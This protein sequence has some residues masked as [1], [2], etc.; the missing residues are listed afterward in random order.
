[1]SNEKIFSLIQELNL[2]ENNFSFKIFK[3]FYFLFKAKKQIKIIIKYI[4]IIIEAI[5]FISYI[6]S[7]NHFDSWKLDINNLKLISN[8]TGVFKLSILI[9]YINYKAYSVILYIFLIFIFF[10]CLIVFVQILI[11]NSS[12]N[13]YRFNNIIRLFIDILIIIFYIPITEIILIP[14]KCVD[15]KV[16]GVKNGETCWT[17][18]HYLNMALGILSSILFFIW[19]IFMINFSFY[20]F[21]HLESTIRIN[22]NNDIIIIIMKL[23]LILQYLL[24]TNEYISL[25]ILLSVSI[26]IFFSCKYN[27]T[28]NN[29]YL[30]MAVN[31]KNSIVMWSYF[32][33]LISKIF[34]QYDTNEF[35]Y[36]LVIGYPFIVYLSIIRIKEKDFEDINFTENINNV[37]NYIRKINFNIRL[38][39]SFIEGNRSIRNF[40]ENQE[41]KD[42][43]LLKGF[44]RF[45]LSL[46]PKDDCPLRKFINNE[47]NANIQKQCLLN[48]MNIFFNKGFKKFP[49]S[50]RL[51]IIYIQFNYRN[52]SNL[53]KVK[54]SL[55][56]L[57]TMECSIKDKYIIYCLEQNIQ[58]K[59]IIK[60]DYSNKNEKN[61]ESQLDIIEQKYQK[62]KYLIENSIKLYVEFWGIFSNN[63]TSILN[64]NTLYSIGGKLNI[65]LKEIN[66]LWENELKNKKINIENQYI[67]QLYSKFLLE[68]LWDRKKSLEISNKL[69]YE[70]LNNF[71]L[72]DKKDKEEKNK[73]SSIIESLIDNE[74]FLLFCSCD[75]KGNIK[76]IQCSTSLTQLLGYQ[77]Y[78]IIGKPIEIIFP[79]LLVEEQLKY[80]EDFIKLSSNGKNNE[81]EFLT[82]EEKDLNKKMK[83][84]IVKNSIGYILPLFASFQTINDND[85]SEAHLIKIKM[86]MKELKSEY[87]YYILTNQD[88]IIENISLGAINLGLSLDLLKNY[89]IKIDTLI[90]TESD[91]II[92]IYENY[93]KY[94]EE[95]NIVVWI[96]PYLI[97]PKYN[98][99]KKKIK[100]DYIEKLIEKSK[101]I[102]IYIQI[103]IIKFNNENYN[104]PIFFFKFDEI[105]S[106]KKKNI[107]KNEFFIPKCDNNL[108]M[109]DI[110][111]LEYIR[112]LVVNK[113]SG[114]RNVRDIDD[115]KEHNS[116]IH[117]E[118]NKKIKKLKKNLEIEQENESSDDLEINKNEFLLTKE[119]IIEL[120]GSTYIEIK[121]FIFSL[122]II[123]TDI[124]FERFRP[125]GE[126]YSASKITESL[127]KIHVNN[128]IKL[129]NKNLK[130]EQK[131]KKTKK[132]YI[133]NIDSPKSSNTNNCL[134]HPNSSS[135]IEFNGKNSDLEK[136]EINKE[137]TSDL[138]SSLSNI[139]KSNTIN[140]I[141]LLVWT[142]FFEIL[143]FVLI[144]FILVHT[145][146]KKIKKK[147]Y[148]L[149]NGYKIE[150]NFL[151]IK[152]FITEGVLGISLNLNY[153]P[154]VNMGGL[155]PF[156]E[157]IIRALTENREEF[158]EI[159]D[160][161]TSNELCK[162]YKNFMSNKV[163]NISTRTLNKTENI[164]IL[165]NSGMTRI[166]S[167]VNN[168]IYE[169]NLMVMNNR[170]TYEIMN[171]LINE[172]YINW[173]KVI[174]ILFNDSI[175]AT[176]LKLPLIIILSIYFIDSFII[177]FFLLKLLSKFSLD[178]EKP[179]NLFLTLKKNV[180]ENLKLSAENFSNKLLNK[181]FDNEDKEEES[182]QD[183]RANIQQNDINI[184]KFKSANEYN[185]SIKKAFSFIL[186]IIL[187]VFF[188]LIY[189]F[190]FTFKY[191]YFRKKMKSI[192]Q[193]INLFCETNMAQIEYI[194][195]INI[196]KSYLFNKTIPILNNKS[197]TNIF[198]E[199]FMKSSQKLEETI[200]STSKATS[201][202]GKEYLKKFSKYFYSDFSELNKELF[203][204]NKALFGEK[205]KNGLKPVQI[206][207]YEIIRYYSLK[208]CISY[209]NHEINIEDDDI[210]FILKLKEFKIYELNVLVE[211]T[212]RIWYREVLNFFI[213][214]F[215]E[216][217]E[218]SNLI[219]I[220]LFIS[221]MVI[222][223]LYYFIIWR[224]YQEQL[225]ILLKNSSDLINL[226]PQ[227]IK[228]IIFEMINE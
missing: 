79:N 172:Y 204:G 4:E 10:L 160:T 90:R 1:M 108:I 178:R 173:E 95:Q 165:F 16:D 47:G 39:N 145:Q 107:L 161:F 131:N 152:Y 6:F 216:Y 2:N 87:S 101:K 75:E 168:L 89:V 121:D 42:I 92:N 174:N 77:K 137:L 45:H 18:I 117:Q 183:Y 38:I 3:Y 142:L 144:D 109:F 218:R 156:I 71:H 114:M 162:E 76:I 220:I 113:K 148:F 5:Q 155:T 50:I 88:L 98:N 147:I 69:K 225:Y 151:Y 29:I 157:N 182:H 104:N 170:D 118:S 15:G 166:Y 9:Q 195:S 175:E 193:F 8:L 33:L 211:I 60:F 128:F 146:I 110:L 83:L 150:N 181:Y 64:T 46:C 154:V 74:D 103:K 58:D 27:S 167:G 86:E 111:K 59:K 127:I 116:N 207:F 24:I 180:F 73:K 132:I 210:S 22:S 36:L 54:T 203:E 222:A 219:F 7:T 11:I 44:I 40:D 105:Y 93:S 32:T 149:N 136:Q 197:T 226:I 125:N 65:L 97:Y 66:I 228:N 48:Y 213:I 192:F 30:E 134:I 43:I 20:P 28:Y 135:S 187:V 37:N 214:F 189:L 176:N 196:F 78:N 224:M 119:K 17:Y 23:F 82:H 190:Y 129:F 13:D 191:Y 194:L 51:L 163:I 26:I 122:P 186:I 112:T 34:Y 169:P 91:K 201:F 221:A 141:K 84:I 53:N 57:K 138:S 19:C 164:S 67:V 106:N 217:L 25:A 100:E 55:L 52:S 99:K 199:N 184:I 115:E 215:D 102:N 68:I 80:L 202:L 56:K 35:I 14:I 198:I 61:N 139:F 177:I 159:F 31:I 205:I 179:I 188:I 41:Q 81:E 12:S 62:L 171:N 133:T 158:T 223:V 123:G 72:N 126:K 140:S 49:N 130:I 21:Q 143:I 70:N 185:Y 94:E 85:Y 206:R 96:Y 209:Y 63:I 124:S 227:E 200:I 120:Q 153:T 212:M 208:Y